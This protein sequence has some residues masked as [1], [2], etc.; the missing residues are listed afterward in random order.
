MFAASSPLRYCPPRSARPERDTV[1]GAS[2]EPH[3]KC[4]RPGDFSRLSPG[5]VWRESCASSALRG[6]VCAASERLWDGVSLGFLLG[7]PPVPR[8]FDPLL[9]VHFHPFPTIRV[10]GYPLPL[11]E[12]GKAALWRG[13][14]LCQIPPRVGVLVV[15]SL[16][17]CRM[18][19]V[20]P[21]FVAGFSRFVHGSMGD[22]RASLGLRPSFV[23]A[24]ISFSVSSARSKP[25]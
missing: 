1:P 20:Q 11:Q 5:F 2:W 15:R 18:T 17:D 13:F 14:R 21:L 12:L 8:L 3:R 10:L 16:F 7:S 24:S 23:L 25:S 9:G 22:S 4:A 6:G 19:F